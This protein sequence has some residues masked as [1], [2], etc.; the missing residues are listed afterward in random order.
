LPSNE[1]VR[2]TLAWAAAFFL[3]LL[4][5][6]LTRYS[7]LLHGIPGALLFASIAMAAW[8][9]YA[10]PALFAVGLSLLLFHSVL[11]PLAP[12]LVMGPGS[13]LRDLVFALVAVLLAV[14]NL[15]L[16]RS[17]TQAA[18]RANE[19]R[20]AEEQREALLTRAQAAESNLREVIHTYADQ[21]KALALAQ[22]A[23]KCAAWILDTKRMQVKWLP[24]GFPIFGRPFEDFEGFQPPITLVEKE[25]QPAILEALERSLTTGVPFT[26]EFRLRWP[27]GELHWQEARG[28]CDPDAPHLIRGT[29]FDITERKQ[30]EL[31][32]LS[33]EKLAAVGRLASTIA[34]EIN[35][36]LASVT[37]LLYLARCDDGLS[38]TVRRYLETAEQELS[39]LSNVT[40]LTLSY[41][42]PQSMARHVNP[43]EVA[44]SVLFL[45]RVRLD[46]KSIRVEHLVLDSLSIY[47]FA[48]ELQRILTNLVANSIDAAPVEGG[49]LR[50]KV[51]RE[52]SQALLTV[53]DSG[54]GIPPET[55]H[56]IFEPFFTTKG[57]VGTGIGLWVTRQLVEKNGGSITLV[58]EG[59]DEGM[60]TRF[61]VR[62]PLVQPPAAADDQEGNSAAR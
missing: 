26:P 48:D 60:R 58:S 8:F 27:N 6:L 54:C 18:L 42:R 39:R 41:A 38:E 23:G 33:V 14:L 2:K 34:H 32:L 49:L 10:W 21:V 13:L 56:R 5:T 44:A 25:D 11:A 62:F 12:R 1:G 40:R 30:A 61:E 55:V 16:R 15:V 4:S 19:L 7:V 45:F 46:A 51:E 59:L 43:A 3:P 9:G 24:G 22:Q 53:E 50:I 31:G 52:D 47:L 37:N 17:L 29:T 36:P 35:N 57:E 28:V 20:E